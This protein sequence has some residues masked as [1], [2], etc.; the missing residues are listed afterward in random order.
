MQ[1]DMNKRKNPNKSKSTR[2]KASLFLVCLMLISVINLAGQVKAETYDVGVGE[3]WTVEITLDGHLLY[4]YSF[5][6][7]TSSSDSVKGIIR[8][9]Y[10]DGGYLET[11]EF[12][13]TDFSL[14]YSR[15]YI[16]NNIASK[17]I[18]E[19]LTYGGRIIECYRIPH[20][21]FMVEGNL[22]VENSTGIVVEEEHY[23]GR[24]SQFDYK[25]KL[26]S[27]DFEIGTY[28]KYEFENFLFLN[29]IIAYFAIVFLIAIFISVKR[30]RLRAFIIQN[31]D[32]LRRRFLIMNRIYEKANQKSK[33]YLILLVFYFLFFLI[34]PFLM[35]LLGS[36]QYIPDKLINLIPLYLLALL[37][38]S[39][40]LDYHR[41]RK[42]LILDD[43][44]KTKAKEK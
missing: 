21:S 39:W 25:L 7:S 26:I 17:A 33:Q 11:Q 15:E 44:Q 14:V 13:L 42:K 30:V 18:L 6:V 34:T 37:T 16:I 28:I 8:T 36:F 43:I 20:P 40:Y 2:F 23:A 29:L 4:K 12:S 41:N 31:K 10:A 32:N 35:F 27:W 24:L 9:I 19:N 38:F 1:K 3:S 5:Q 22:V